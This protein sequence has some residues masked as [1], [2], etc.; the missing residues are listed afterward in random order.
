MLYLMVLLYLIANAY[1]YDLNGYKGRYRNVN[2]FISYLVLALM[3]GLR[4]KMGSDGFAYQYFVEN[5]VRGLYE[6]DFDYLL[7]SRFQPLWI[8]LSATAK[9]LGN[10]LY[11]QFFVSFVTLFAVY[12]FV[13]K[14][15]PYVAT[16]T[17]FFYISFY[18]YFSMEILRESLA[19]SLFLV[20]M[21]VF[22]RHKFFSF[23]LCL[24][25][26]FIHKFAIFIIIV[27]L[28]L[29]L[30]VQLRKTIILLGLVIVLIILLDEPI[31]N[32]QLA[33]SMIKDVNFSN[34]DVDVNLSLVGYLYYMLKIFFPVLLIFYCSNRRVVLSR[35]I[36]NKMF[37]T[38]CAFYSAIY[39]IRI[40]SLP[41]IERLVNYFELFYILFGSSLLVYF[42]SKQKF[43][44]RNIVFLVIFTLSLGYS[45]LPLLKPD[46]RTG[47]PSYVIYYPYY[48]YLNKG[49]DPM[50]EASLKDRFH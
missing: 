3:A 31:K 10:Y 8:L 9:T 49:T 4:Y 33:Y 23:S 47:I 39:I 24:T 29:L 28:F 11:L 17:L 38:F 21:T 18:H 37:Y 20:S 13:K 42:L 36:D 15:T 22:K 43:I 16:V 1:A 45:W 6:L 32:I 14:N 19:I 2:I 50:R 7:D 40:F 34:Y 46:A 30:D 44:I 26:F 27:Y 48:S 35:V 12:G 41:Y 5:E 25:A